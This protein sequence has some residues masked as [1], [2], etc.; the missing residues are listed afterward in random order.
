MG[1]LPPHV[2][3]SVLGFATLF[4][5]KPVYR[6]IGLS[7]LSFCSK[8]KELHRRLPDLVESAS[9]FMSEEELLGQ[10]QALVGFMEGGDKLLK[11]SGCLVVKRVVARGKTQA[12]AAF[13]SAVSPRLLKAMLEL[14]PSTEIQMLW[15]IINLS[16]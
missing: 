8:S 12:L 16:N 9:Q 2:Q 1:N 7:L 4:K 14:I 3:F 6:E 15:P 11:Y 10:L 13:F 5:D